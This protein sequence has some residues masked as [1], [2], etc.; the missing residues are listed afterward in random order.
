MSLFGLQHRLIVVSLREAGTFVFFRVGS[1]VISV[2]KIVA[3]AFTHPVTDSVNR[4][5]KTRSIGSPKYE[6]LKLRKKKK[7]SGRR[8]TLKQSTGHMLR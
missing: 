8:I 4:R 3:K 2:C 7:S 6:D 5:A 1:Y